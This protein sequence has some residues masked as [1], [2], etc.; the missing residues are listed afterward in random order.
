MNKAPIQAL[1]DY[2]SSIF[3]PAVLVIAVVTFIVWMILST[4]WIYVCVFVYM[5]V[6]V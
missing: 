2:I 4:G 1:A 6:D 3:V 5:Y